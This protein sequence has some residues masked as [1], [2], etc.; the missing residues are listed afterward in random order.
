[1]KIN[2]KTTLKDLKGDVIKNIDQTDFL[3]G[4]AIGNILVTD[5]TAGKYKL[6]TLA[7]K[8]A[9]EDEVE[10]DGPD[11]V[12]IKKAVED[13]KRYNALVAGQILQILETK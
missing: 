4:D 12:M 11:L 7:Q 9:V 8:F 3:V 1:M 2:T 13:T 10:V 5:E 6:Y